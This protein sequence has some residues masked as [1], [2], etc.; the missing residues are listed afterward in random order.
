MPMNRHAPNSRRVLVLG[1]VPM[2]A[3]AQGSGLLPTLGH[4]SCVELT[5]LA[6]QLRTH[7]PADVLV[8]VLLA[9]LEEATLLKVDQIC[10]EAGTRWVA[11]HLDAGLGWLGPAVEPPCSAK[12]HDLLQRRRCAA[13]QLDLHQALIAPIAPGDLPPW[14]ELLWMFAILCR[15]IAN[16]LNGQACRLINAE[17]CLDPISCTVQRYPVLPLPDSTA[18]QCPNPQGSDRELLSERAGIVLQL[19]PLRHHASLPAS[20]SS[21]QAYLPTMQRYDPSWYNVSSSLG[22]SFDGIAAAQSAALGEAIERYCMNYL[23]QARP[24]K[25]SY[26]Q[27]IARGDAAVDPERLILFSDTIYTTP[28]CPFTRFTHDTEQY[29]VRGYALHRQQPAWMPLAFVYTHWE[30]GP[31]ADQPRVSDSSF[32]GVA[33][34]RTL[35]QALVAA[36]E[37]LIERDS[38]MLWWLNAQPLPA[39]ILPPALAAIWAG[40]PQEAGQR[41]WALALPNEFAI[42]VIA[43]V[44]EQCHEQLLNIGFACRPDPLLATRKAWA[45]A[46]TLQERSRDLLQPDSVL[47]A[48]FATEGSAALLKPWRADRS[49]SAAYRSD[50]R[51]M[52]HS[53]CAEQFY[54]DPRAI[55]RVR[56]WVEGAAQVAI[57]A[58]PSLPNRALATY[59]QRLAQRGYEIFSYE[60]TTPE[61]RQCGWHVVRVLIPGLI[62]EFPAAF[63]HT[64]QGRAQRLP[65]AL[66]WCAT[67][68]READLNY[69]P[70]PYA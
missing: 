61:L 1:D 55:E 53:I 24:I 33:A 48:E 26:R 59:Q 19:L 63:P 35:E 43:G 14:P 36:I 29:W 46:L 17:L 69:L 30:T 6:Q 34:G 8:L 9:Q 13:P 2:L 52:V 51:D 56:P 23:A 58:L 64:G 3:V 70:L 50:F 57:S 20:L 7:D 49:Y 41:A 39:L 62:P 68:R 15:E 18:A 32:P 22:S 4:A 25:A 38:M 47:R 27:L 37:E 44:V 11:W 42:P 31:F 66:G 54:L 60:L 45:E 65:V 28:G 16:W 40:L 10:W 67:P 5:Q 21:V 12:Y